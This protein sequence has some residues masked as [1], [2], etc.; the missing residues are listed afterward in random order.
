MEIL[1][2]KKSDLRNEFT[3][4]SSALRPRGCFI[5]CRQSSGQEDADHSVSITQQLDNC[6]KLAERLGIK[7]K[8]VFADANIS[9]KTYPAGREFQAIAAA[10][11]A[12]QEWYRG[13]SSRKMYREGLGCMLRRLGEVGYVV[14]DEATRL[15]RS[16]SKSFLEQLIN[17]RFSS[18]GVKILQ[19]KGGELDFSRFDQSLIQML[20]TQIN[21]EQIA[22]QRKKSIESRIRIK[23]SGVI[24]HAAFFAAGAEGNH[25]FH[26]DP[27]KAEVV[28][29]I[30]D[31]ILRDHPYGQIVSD[32]NLRYRGLF[33]PAKRFYETGFYRIAAQPAYAGYMYNSRGELIHCVNA[34]AP[35]ITIGRFL[36][37]QELMKRKRELG[38][39]PR[40][41]VLP[42]R[43]LPLSGYVRCGICGSRMIP[44]RDNHRLFYICKNAFLTRDP[45][46]RGIRI[47]AN[48]EPGGTPAPG[49]RQALLP[50]AAAAYVH[51][52][53]RL[54]A[55]TGTSLRPEALQAKIAKL[56]R[57]IGVAFSQ[58]CEDLMDEELYRDITRKAVAEVRQLKMRLLE[59]ENDDAPARLCEA[60][61]MRNRFPV[62]ISSIRQLEDRDFSGL[63]RELLHSVEVYPKY[64]VIRTSQGDFKLPRR[65]LSAKRK[66]MPEW[67]LEAEVPGQLSADGAFTL[68]YDCRDSP[69]VMAESPLTCQIGNLHIKLRWQ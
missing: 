40:G 44:R 48:T 28:K 67:T 23:D 56:Q 26:F 12:F 42:R 11:M 59:V 47:F 36:Q 10:D 63:M 66:W 62:F 43:R 25:R 22:N 31:S 35:L 4:L 34:P 55:R 50:L 33:A 65:N 61:E 21:D 16:S 52:I 6:R 58:F 29:F 18:A 13:Q 37:V 7:I 68:I 41:A 32:V 45:E 49:L 24:A 64:I 54:E 57:K 51:R 15:H 2:M 19:V 38:S 60:N 69:T 27:R 53:A 14:V 39:R 8:D 20:R 5:Y 3:P 9:G 17:Y 46:C 1:R 30:F